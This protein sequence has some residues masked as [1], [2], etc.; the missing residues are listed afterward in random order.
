MTDF[1]ATPRHLGQQIARC[2]VAH[3]EGATTADL[4]AWAYPEPHLR[5]HRG[6]V[7][8]HMRACER[9]KPNPGSLGEL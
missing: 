8:R 6:N 9:S 2:L 5:W 1:W 4:V 7:R 3:S